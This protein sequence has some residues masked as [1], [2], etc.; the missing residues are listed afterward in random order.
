MILPK[1]W[2]K[3][4]PGNEELCRK[5]GYGIFEDNGK[6][7]YRLFVPEGEGV[8]PMAVYLH[9]ADAFGNDNEQ[10]LSIHD[11][12]TCFAR[13]SWQEKEPCYILAPQCRPKD[14]WSLRSSDGRVCTLIEKLMAEDKRID[15]D[16]IYIYGYSAG[17]IGTLRIIKERPEIF[18]AAVSICG[19]TE[20]DKLDILGEKPLW[21]IH[22][23][24]DEIVRN[25]YRSDDPIKAIM[26][27]A[28][29]YEKL[30]EKNR[31]IH[32]TEYPAGYMKEKYG[33]NPHCTWV[34]AAEDEE[35]KRWL[36]TRKKSYGEN[37]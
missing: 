14:H 8:F 36:F 32:Y 16:R 18:A 26:G 17:G 20:R 29:I 35:M 4:S 22:A 15:P 7:P 34:S 11:I 6:L 1:D 19:A 5:F 27:S 2:D 23:E 31:D 24:D 10:Q 21:L 37:D 12:G 13:E 9:G 33:V 30:K 3:P 25:Y 28:E